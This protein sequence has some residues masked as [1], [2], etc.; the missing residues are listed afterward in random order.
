VA[1]ITD[2]GELLR[3][4]RPVLNP[5]TVVFT[6]VP[7]GTDLSA[8]GALASVREPEGVSL[9][10]DEAV[11]HAATLPIH[12][13]AA[14]IT[15]TVSSALEAVGLTAAVA[16]ALAAAGISCN[17]VAGTFH[18]HLFVPVERA[19]EAVAVLDGLARGAG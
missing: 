13:R 18:D 11:A 15:L 5:G 6:T 12:F 14:W 8:L 7:P 17:V 10:L 1:P 3:S 4:L 16:T 9:I 19:L 2:L